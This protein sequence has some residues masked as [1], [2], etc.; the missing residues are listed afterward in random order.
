MVFYVSSRLCRAEG[1][2]NF[3]LPASNSAPMLPS[4]TLQPSPIEPSLYHYLEA[5]L[6]LQCC[7]Y[8]FAPTASQSFHPLV[9][10]IF[11]S[12]LVLVAGG[13]MAAGIDSY[14]PFINGAIFLMFTVRARNPY[15]KGGRVHGF[16]DRLIFS[17]QTQ[18]QPA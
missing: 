2:S 14:F 9:F 15:Q 11:T 4:C 12:F 10:R 7:K 3:R 8:S 13:L 1:L 17:Y 6:I 5:L 16:F 18:N